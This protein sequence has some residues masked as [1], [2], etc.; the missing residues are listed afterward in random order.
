[1]NNITGG[2]YLLLLSFNKGNLFPGTQLREPFLGT[3][4]GNPFQAGALFPGT[5]LWESF[6]KKPLREPFAEALSG[7]PLR[8]PLSKPLLDI[9]EPFAE[10]LA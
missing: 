2:S 5:L 7:T 10:T 3:L 1:M 6:S 8:E 9:R 4:S